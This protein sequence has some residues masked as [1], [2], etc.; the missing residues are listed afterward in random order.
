MSSLI[1]GSE[2][3]TI[4]TPTEEVTPQT[5]TPTTETPTTETPVTPTSDKPSYMFTDDMP[6]EGDAPEWFKGEK[7]KTVS[8]QAKAYNE[9]EGRFGSFTGAPKDGKYE[10][11]GMDFEES[12]L[13]KLTDD[14]GVE[15]Q[16]FKE[17]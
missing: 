8:D 11:E 1:P 14:W 5:E 3:P 17:G 12:P 4:E 9:L 16:L 7:Y 2:T 13:L 10:I 15:S 6:G